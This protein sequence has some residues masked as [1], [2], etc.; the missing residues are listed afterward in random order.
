MNQNQPPTQF[1]HSFY[2]W[3]ATLL[4]LATTSACNKPAKT[5]ADPPPAAKS[6][7]PDIPVLPVKLGDTWRYSVKVEIPSKNSSSETEGTQPTSHLDRRYIGKLK[8]AK[9]LPEVDCFEITAP[10]ISARREFVDIK[11]H[12]ILMRGS[13][14]MNQDKIAPVWLEPGVPFVAAGMK[15]GDTMRE[16]Q[17]GAGKNTRNLQVVAREQI[18]VPAGE[19]NAVR[20]LMT[21]KEGEI[22][23]R[24]TIWFSFQVG[25]IREE[26]LRYSANQLLVR[27]IHELLEKV[28]IP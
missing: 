27:E 17:A 26:K 21:G 10:N 14:V 8:P 25:I 20:L 16:V 18:T 13:M 15:A 4:F 11:D 9:N 1:R 19:F 23:L 24:R 2:V 28:N 6:A 12:I 5:A 22:E 3:P 7:S